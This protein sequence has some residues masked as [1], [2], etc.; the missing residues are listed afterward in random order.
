MLLCRNITYLLQKADGTHQRPE[1]RVHEPEF[2]VVKFLTTDEQGKLTH[3][4]FF[5]EDAEVQRF[6]A[7]T[8]TLDAIC[9]ITK[10]MVV[11]AHER[12]ARGEFELRDLVSDTKDER[13]PKPFVEGKHLEKWLPATNKYLEWGTE[14]HLTYSVAQRSQRFMKLMKKY[15]FS[16]APAQIQRLAMTIFDY[17]LQKVVWALFYG[18]AYLASVIGLSKSRRAIETR[19]RNAQIC[20]AGKNLRKPADASPLSFFLV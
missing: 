17:I 2:G 1:R 3:R 8:A 13:H 7:P 10:G 11:N 20:P 15:S 9:Y 5:P 19:S 16:A 12:K 18:I 14:E 4:A 6:S